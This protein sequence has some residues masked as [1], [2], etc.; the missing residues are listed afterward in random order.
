M[1]NKINTYLIHSS[2]WSGIPGSPTTSAF[3]LDAP[4]LQNK[5]G[6]GMNIF[7][8][9]TGITTRFGT[10][11]SL[12]YRFNFSEST[13]LT[14]GV[15]SGI[16]DNKIG[17][18]QIVVKD[19]SEQ[20]LLNQSGRKT[21]FDATAGS[22][23]SWNKLQIGFSVPQVMNNSLAY[24]QQNDARSFY[25]LSRHYLLSTKY[26]FYISKQKN[27]TASPLVLV[28]AAQNAPLQYDINA[29]FDWNEKYW[30]AMSYKN[31]EAISLNVGIRIKG[32]TI[33]YA[34]DVV[35][36]SA[37]GPYSGPSQ[38]ILIGYAFRNPQKAIKEDIIENMSETFNYKLDSLGRVAKLQNQK[39]DSIKNKVN[40]AEK[41]NKIQFD[42]I[43]NKLD[44]YK[45]SDFSRAEKVNLDDYPIESIF[46]LYN[47]N[48]KSSSANLNYKSLRTLDELIDFMY[49]NPTVK[50]DIHGHTDDVGGEKLNME[51]SI[52]RAFAVYNYLIQNGVAKN[53]L[54][55]KGY[56]K[57]SPLIPGTSDKARE[58]NRRTEF[59]IVEK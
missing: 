58:R 19:G 53:R 8:D 20:S 55:Y 27:F 23:L 33:G 5:L 4:L 32:L 36:S 17:F 56:G 57:S 15:S 2:M 40:E 37:M 42:T 35:N 31:R 11:V 45:S 7:N 47:V 59:V 21:T 34:Y 39:L 9:V 46:R 12:A 29:I 25:L 13:S 3:T 54:S 24:I 18:S 26:T 10:N 28:R 51:L 41:N 50:I 49:I 44:Q 30:M 48:F 22:L 14:L 6:L 16:L 1:D 38:E 52:K 43:N